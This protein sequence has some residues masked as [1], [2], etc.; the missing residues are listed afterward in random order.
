MD[1]LLEY[2]NK[3]QVFL[4]VSECLVSFFLLFIV[5]FYYDSISDFKVF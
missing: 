5:M 2:I 3:L 4:A 1:L